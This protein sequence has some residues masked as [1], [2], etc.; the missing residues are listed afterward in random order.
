MCLIY[1]NVPV[2]S[3][4]HLSVQ[5]VGLVHIIVLMAPAKDALLASNGVVDVIVACLV[6]AIE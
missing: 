5:V 4:L 2:D 3:N 6:L 1:K